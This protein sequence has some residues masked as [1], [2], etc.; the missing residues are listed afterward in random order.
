MTIKK[1][2]LSIIVIFFGFLLSVSVSIYNLQKYDKNVEING[3]TYHLMIKTDSY[4]YLSHG[5]EIKKDLEN[6]INFFDTGRENYTKYLPPRIAAA[7]YYFFNIDLFNN[8]EEKKINT[9]IHFKYLL[10]QCMFYFFC[11][12]ML[13]FSISQILN[14]EI[15]LFI[16]LFLCLEPT[17]FQYHGTFWS[18]SIFFSLQVLLISL[19]L[20]KNSS[21]LNFFAIGFFLAILS[22]QK[23]MSLFYII[24]VIIYLL[25][26]TEHMKF[27]KI[28]SLLIGFI[29]IQAFLGFNNYKRSGQFYIMT[30]DTKIDLHIYLVTRVM[31]KKYEITGMEFNLLEGKATKRWIENNLIEYDK[32][33][34]NFEKNLSFTKYR[35][36]IIKEEDKIRFDNFIRSRTFDYLF[37]YPLDFL[38]HIAKSSM[39]TILLNP[40]HIFSDHNFRSGEYYYTSDTHDKLIPYRIFY[41]ILIYVVCLLGFSALVKQKKISLLIYLFLSILY[42]YGFVCWHGDTRYFVP[43]LIYLS[44]FF[45]I[46]LD[47][48]INIKKKI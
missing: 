42:F 16:V 14:K 12:L 15:C 13:Y 23:Q 25:I 3:K 17:I 4:R 46:G 36:S 24:P 1:I 2:P 6:G 26:F 8:L 27:R 31:S 38:I 19:I 47:K 30:A 34:Y 5:A 22:M 41:S 44:F 45:G 43:V 35:H 18:E 40:F 20:K 21:Y 9:G 29:I 33:N 11:V 32:K 10:F 39:H 28:S 48:I 7:Y 37:K